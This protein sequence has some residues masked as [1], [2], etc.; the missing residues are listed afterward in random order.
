MFLPYGPPFK[1]MVSLEHIS[2]IAIGSG[3]GLA[4]ND[5]LALG[6]LLLNRLSMTIVVGLA[7]A[8]ARQ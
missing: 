3:N 6:R 8:R 1:Q 5:N 4:V 7:A 2:R